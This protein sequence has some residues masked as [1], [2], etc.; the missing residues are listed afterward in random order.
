MLA[1]VGIFLYLCRG[2]YVPKTKCVYM[3]EEF[4]KIDRKGFT[5]HDVQNALSAM[6]TKENTEKL[7]YEMLAWTLVF[8]STK[9]DWGTHHGPCLMGHDK[10]GNPVDFPAYANITPEAVAYWSARYTEVQNPFL[11]ARYCGLV[12]D[13][14]NLLP[15]QRRPAG[16][17][18]A[19]TTALIEVVRGEYLA[20]KWVGKVYLQRA[21]GLLAGNPSK[22]A[23]WKAVL[24]DYVAS[25]ELS[26]KHIGIWCAEVDFINNTHNLFTDAERQRAV[27]LVLQRYAYFKAHPD[28]Y[29]TKE[30]IDLL[31]EHYSCFNQKG[32]A[33]NLLMEY[34]QLVNANDSLSAIQK[35]L[36]YSSI[37]GRLRQL[38]GFDRDEQRV[39]VAMHEASRRGISELTLSRYEFE[40]SKSQWESFINTMTKGD[41]TTQIDRFI[42]HFIPNLD[43][44]KA[45]LQQLPKTHPFAAHASTLLYV[46]DFPGSVVHSVDQDLE[47]NLVLV[48]AGSMKITD[49]FLVSLIQYFREKGILTPDVIDERISK[50]ALI[51]E[52]REQ[53]LMNIV[54]LYYEEQYVT[55][56]H[57]IIPQIE[58]M[59]RTLLQISGVNVIQPQRDRA[60][61]QLKTLDALLREPVIDDSFAYGG[62]KGSVS[63]YLRVLL[64][65]QR[66]CNYR[67]LLCHGVVHPELFNINVASRL[68]HAFMLLLKIEK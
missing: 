14:F 61:Y 58:A 31:Y 51:G 40:I 27:D 37:V 5:E 20:Y 34:E 48:L 26:S 60:G 11:K 24:H 29:A 62:G 63:M 35:E 28:F 68:L 46:G 3:L 56:C 9:N 22:Q 57:L 13:Y 36:H 41:T 52:D 25:E 39:M 49:A 10:D 12:W 42:T 23:E 2:F 44:A 15:D 1:Y 55:F 38:G 47:G 65:D 21:L 6:E 32:A 7:Q 59:I 19:Y 8:S 50:S 43:D 66:G 30:L 18:D 53:M 67:N 33:H 45:E 17:Y 4:D 16:L 64:T 54:K